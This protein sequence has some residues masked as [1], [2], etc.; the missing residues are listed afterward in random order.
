MPDKKNYHFLFTYLPLWGH[1]RSCCVLAARMAKEHRNL[2][3][4]LFLPPTFIK[5]AEAEVLAELSY[6]DE[7]KEVLQ[8]LRR[9]V[10]I[11]VLYKS[12]SMD[13][14]EQM[15]S[16]FEAY[17]A[18]YKTLVDGE[19]VTCASTGRVFE[20]VGAPDI[21]FLDVFASPLMAITRTVTGLS[22]PIIGFI[23]VHASYALHICL[24]AHMGG[25]GDL[26]VMI[27]DE[28]RRLGVTSREIGDTVY[29]RTEGRINKIPGLP[30]MYDWEHFPQVLVTSGSTAIISDLIKLAVQGI[31]DCTAGFSLTPYDFEPESVD[32]LRSWFVDDWKKELYVVGP[33]LA[34]KP[35]RFGV[36]DGTSA[37]GADVSSTESPEVQRFLDNAMQEYGKNSVVLI[38]F[39]SI[40]WPTVNEYID[41]VLEALIEKKFPFILSCASPFAHIAA[42]VLEKI[43]A[44]KCGLVSKWVPQKFVLDHPATGWFIS[45]AGQSGVHESLDSGVPM[46]CWP[47]EFDQ[48]LASAHLTQNLNAAFELVEVRTGEAGLKPILSL[49]GRA[50]KGTRAAVGAEM[51]AV[52]DACRGPEGEE[53][54][55]NMEELR[56]KV[57]GAWGRYV[58]GRSRRDFEAFLEKFGFDLDEVD[59]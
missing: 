42:E 31:K 15:T 19:P 36:T 8:D 11:V 38:S 10:R 4:T 33:L 6:G 57:R 18:T 24:P 26:G 41:E 58:K 20:G 1:T 27:E 7:V 13:L 44:S 53:K 14:M 49:G 55:R 46:I 59:V 16:M 40:F 45:H 32:T 9:R 43:T 34:S 2:T 54:R 30:A 52:L 48:P 47:F 37:L 12:S 17:P 51:R 28:A 25:L 50:P 22:V 35:T 29:Y 23:P 39:G 21:V 5:Q 3:V 56:R